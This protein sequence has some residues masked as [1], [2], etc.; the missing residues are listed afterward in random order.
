MKKTGKIAIAAAAVVV[1]IAA[2]VTI[3]VATRP[4]VSA[5]DKTITVEVVHGDESTNTFTYET[6]AEYLGEVLLSEG[7]VEGDESE[8]GLYI[9][10]VDGE[11]AD[12]NV[13]GAYWALYV[14]EEYAT[15]GADTTPIS[16]GDE[17]SLVYTV[18]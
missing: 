17:F 10:T 3:Y 11:T 1:L 13:N 5:G 12:Y 14:G 15:Q 16:D 7:L 4:A 18:G 9:T 2:L 8:Y 6:D